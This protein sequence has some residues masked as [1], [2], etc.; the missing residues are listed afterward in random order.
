MHHVLKPFE[1]LHNIFHA[2]MLNENIAL[3]KSS[4]SSWKEDFGSWRV[5]AHDSSNNILG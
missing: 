5:P 2:Y 4:H 3:R 1:N